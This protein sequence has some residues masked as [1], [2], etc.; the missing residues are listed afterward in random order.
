MDEEVTGMDRKGAGTILISGRKMVVKKRRFRKGK[1]C[2]V[3]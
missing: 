1:K 3:Y 2:E